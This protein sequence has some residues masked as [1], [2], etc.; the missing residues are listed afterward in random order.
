MKLSEKQRTAVYLARKSWGTVYVL[1]PADLL[2][3]SIVME[4]NAVRYQRKQADK[5]KP[6]VTANDAGMGIRRSFGEL[7]EELEKLS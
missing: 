7:K 1:G 5:V 3:W 6:K 4:G 2:P